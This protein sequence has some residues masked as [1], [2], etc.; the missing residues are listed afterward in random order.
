MSDRFP[1]FAK[2]VR[3]AAK[4]L[5]QHD[6]L[7]VVDAD[8]DLLWKTYLGAFP[9]GTDL[10]FR[11]KTEHDCRICSRFVK[12]MSKVVAVK[13]GVMSTIWDHDQLPYPYQT[14]ADKMAEY[15]TSCKVSDIFLSDAA[16]FT[17]VE[18]TT[19]AHD[20]AIKW[21]HFAVDI[22]ARFT[23][24]D[25]G[26]K[27]A[28]ARSNHQVFR[29]GVLEIKPDAVEAVLDMISSNNL[30]R[31]AE[32]EKEV[33]AFQKLQTK[34]LALKGIA[35][36][37]AFW[38]YT[39]EFGAGIRNNV[40]GTLLVAISDGEPIENAVKSFETKV[41]PA[42]Y[43]RPTPVFT[44][45]MVEEAMQT[46]ADLDLES[47]LERRH[48]RLSDVHITSVLWVDKSAKGKLKGG[49]ADMLMAETK[50]NVVIEPKNAK[51]ITIADFLALNHKQGMKLYF[52]NA[53]SGHLMSLTAPVHPEV[54]Q[55]FKW[56]NDFSWSY[57]GNVTD[58][59][60][61]TQVAA[62][63]GRVD[64]VFR[65]SHTWNYDPARPNKSLMDLHVFMPGCS[66][67][68]F[69]D[70]SHGTDNYGT[71]QRVGWNR[72]NDP[73]SG[74]VQDVDYDKNFDDKFV[75]VENIT[76]PDLQR[77]PEGEYVLKI[78]N[79]QERAR[80][81]NIS[82]FRAE[83]E[84]GGQIYQYEHP[85]AVGHKKWVTVAKVR[86]KDGQ[87][88]IEHV[89]PC[90]T[91]SQEHWGLKTQDLI[92]V[93]A[94]VQSPNFWGDNEV[95]NKHWFFIL[96]GCKNP[97]PCRGIYNEYLHPRLEKHRKVFE[98]VGNKTKCPVVDEQLSGLG[99][100]STNRDVV[101]AVSNGITYAVQ[102]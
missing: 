8:A 76:F 7:Y 68:K 61:R 70:A 46:L 43:K 60:L 36:D 57:K 71:G 101:F 80:T 33:V 39:S 59:L 48:A 73:L 32:H 18:K 87:F 67:A 85:E 64:G 54:K 31:G 53:L 34:L 84:F 4:A 6:R 10:V 5:L 94:V 20:K 16:A 21:E 27:L 40:I 79:W 2:A 19:D 26:T 58:S 89:L 42:N 96:E 78:H 13:N 24:A 91:A 29:R 1:M 74:G 55:L 3:A 14:V 11:T 90:G 17:G 23:P 44:K 69:P 75:P 98:M 95:G 38:E 88:S 77:M 97:E 9:A 99:F 56:D 41:A 35:R 93:T 65:F 62:L 82:G 30:Y 100:S 66:A 37:V 12:F 83:I 102:F 25:A 81:T 92:K 15:V 63:G 86:L 52:D 45:K 22:P 51:K 49:I 28:A 47:A 72:R 50:T